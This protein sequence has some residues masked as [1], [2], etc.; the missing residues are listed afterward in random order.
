MSLKTVARLRIAVC[1]VVLVL[2]LAALSGAARADSIWNA[3]STKP[4]SYYSS[5][6]GEHNIGDIIT[7]IILESFNASNTTSTGTDKG[8][9][10]GASFQGFESLLGITHVAGRPLTDDPSMSLGANSSFDGGG[11]SRRSSSI[12][13]TIT[14]QVTEVLKNGNLRFEA[15]QTTI[16]NGEKNS[17]ILLGTIRPQDVTSGNTVFSTQL[18]NAEIR[19]DGVGPLSTVQKRG[20]VTEFLEFIWPF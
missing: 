12:T 11:S 13:G 10:F 9:D 14:G 4:S 3:A 6:K 1:L 7:V 17:V 19:Y 16:I 15:S 2:F 20:V 5:T 8:T 18:S